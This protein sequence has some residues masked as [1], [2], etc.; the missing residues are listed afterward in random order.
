MKKIEKLIRVGVLYPGLRTKQI[1][2][3]YYYIDGPEFRYGVLTSWWGDKG[4]KYSRVIES[5]GPVTEWRWV[6]ETLEYEID[7]AFINDQ[8]ILP[9]SRKELKAIIKTWKDEEEQE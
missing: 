1:G 2:N 9:T 5:D 8:L 7:G 6:E 3:T 4:F